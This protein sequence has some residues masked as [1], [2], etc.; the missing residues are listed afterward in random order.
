MEFQTNSHLLSWMVFTPLIGVILILLGVAFRYLFRLSQGFADNF[1]R[2]VGLISTL[3]VLLQGV[4]LWLGYDGSVGGLH[5]KVD[6][7]FLRLGVEHDFGVRVGQTQADHL[8]GAPDQF[9]P[10]PVAV[11]GEAGFEVGHVKAHAVELLYQGCGFHL[12]S[13]QRCTST[14]FPSGSVR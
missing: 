8:V 4:A 13:S 14:M 9:V 10:Q 6:L 12:F 2:T 5:L 1:A 11:E 3:A 7:W